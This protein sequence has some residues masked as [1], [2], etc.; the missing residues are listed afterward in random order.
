MDSVIHLLNNWGMVDKY[1]CMNCSLFLSATSRLFCIIHCFQN[2]VTHQ[3][4]KLMHS[5]HDGET[6][7][8]I[9]PLN[10]WIMLLLNY[11]NAPAST[12]PDQQVTTF[13]TITSKISSSSRGLWLIT[14]ALL[15][16][17]KGLTRTALRQSALTATWQPWKELNLKPWFTTLFD[18]FKSWGRIMAVDSSGC[19]S[20]ATITTSETSWTSGVK[21]RASEL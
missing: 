16:S 21:I 1:G 19:R 15:N 3:Q 20:W 6:G 18:G 13:S 10:N 17:H 4:S 9:K 7:L 8:L 5:V 12:D 14:I 2:T 11:R